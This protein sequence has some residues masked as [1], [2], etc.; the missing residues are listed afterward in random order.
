MPINPIQALGDTWLKVP[1]SYISRVYKKVKQPWIS[2]NQ[3]EDY[4][5]RILTPPYISNIPDVHH[6]TPQVPYFLLLGSDGLLSTERYNEMNAT[7]VLEHWANIL[8]SAIDSKT[9]TNVNAAVRL[10]RD[11][12]G[13]D[14]VDMVSR[15]LTVEMDER[16]V[17]DITILIQTVRIG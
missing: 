6:L 15:N 4:A 17:D 14:D 8:G 5:L 2:P 10:L 16:W 7:Q 3:F 13:G 12:L 1:A 11:I 9:E